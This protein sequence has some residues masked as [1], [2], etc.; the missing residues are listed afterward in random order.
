VLDRILSAPDHANLTKREL[1]QRCKGK[2]EIQRADDLDQPLELLKEHHYVR[3]ED[4]SSTSGR[5]PSP[6]IVLNPAVLENMTKSTKSLQSAPPD[7]TSGT[8]GDVWG[9]YQ[10]PDEADQQEPPAGGAA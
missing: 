3:V 1:W 5:P 4:R 6:M 8:F 7:D 2:R 10:N 9:R